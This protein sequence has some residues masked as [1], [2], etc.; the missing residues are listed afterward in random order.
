M[1]KIQAFLDTDIIIASLLSEKGA[2]YGII[3]NPTID[4]IVSEFIEKET[5]EVCKRLNI[6][7][8]NSENVFKDM[9]IL[10]IGSTKPSI[11]KNYKDFVF[12]ENDTHVIAGAHKSKSKFLL[13]HNIKHFKIDRIKAKLGIITL[14]P[15]NFLQYLRS[16]DK[17]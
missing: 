9:K 5:E 12:D 11:L 15:G 8:K 17:F 1:A 14:K 4:K 16:I 3:K 13:T 2:S 10:S 7:I 6:D